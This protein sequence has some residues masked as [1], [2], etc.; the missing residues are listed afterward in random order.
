MNYSL[1]KL[2]NGIR[3]IAV[4]IP[5]LSSATVT[6]WANTGSRWEDKKIG[7]MSHFL[8]HMVFKG[9]KKRPTS[10][11]IFGAVDAI[12][13]EINAATS[14]DW[15]NYY[16]KSR[17]PSLNEAFDVLSD[18]VLNPLLKQDEIDR[19]KGVIIEEIRMHDDTPMIKISD[20]FENLVFSDT[21]LGRDIAGT[22]KT[23]GSVSRADFLRYR[24]IH[25][26]PENLIITVAGGVTKAEILKLA[27]KYFGA[28]TGKKNPGTYKKYSSTQK[29]PQILL[30][31]KKKEQ[32]HFIL[33]F[34]GE[35]RSYKNRYAEAVLATILGASASSRLFIE[36][37]ERR[38]LCYF[39]KSSVER[40]METGYFA[41]QA[42]VDT[43]RVD[44]AIKVTLAEHYDLASGVKPIS[45][46]ELKKAKE[47]LKGHISLN[48]ED[49]REVCE[50]F[51]DQCLFLKEI[52]TPRKVF[53]RLDKVTIEQV[54][55]EAKKLFRPER[56][57]L[58]L[59]GPYEDESRF[60]KLLK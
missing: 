9:S 23:V 15:T 41:T 28:L 18:M 50:F 32:A 16:I 25:Y 37:R 26:Y 34:R 12:G 42:G 6:V 57:N 48:L 17:A 7:G 11:D 54:L 24:T 49:T 46:K 59:I 52:I 2:K 58:A 39:I 45:Q 3:V 44:E 55:K 21:P 38:G 19:E 60:R 51:G 36:V 20:L 8:E 29:K 33:G 56:L 30:W 13:G 43:K 31:D 14:K 27:N 40:Y 4:P 1:T 53:E 5:G 35:G 22:E 10:K 47:F